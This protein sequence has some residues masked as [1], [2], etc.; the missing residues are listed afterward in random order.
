MKEFSRFFRTRSDSNIVEIRAYLFGLM[1]AK[2]G[3]KNI[4]CIEED[5]NSL[6]DLVA[7]CGASKFNSP[8]QSL[9]MHSIPK[10]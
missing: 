3:A 2:R 9:E 8:I 1:Q 4:E 7:G 6:N 5:Q 10:G